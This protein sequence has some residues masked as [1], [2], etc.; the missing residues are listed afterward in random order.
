MI[1]DYKSSGSLGAYLH[2]SS[3][4]T[5][6]RKFLKESFEKTSYATKKGISYI[7]HPKTEIISGLGLFLGGGAY[8]FLNMIDALLE[9]GLVKDYTFNSY[10]ASGVI[11]AGIVIGTHGAFREGKRRGINLD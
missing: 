11:A 1:M 4:F 8:L 2:N 7:T 5:D 3:K 6:I 9:T 10:V